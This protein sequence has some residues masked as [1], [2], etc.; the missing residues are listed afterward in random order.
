MLMPPTAAGSA[1]TEAVL[2]SIN[3]NTYGRPYGHLLGRNGQ[4]Y[5]TMA[6]RGYAPYCGGYF[7]IV[8]PT[9]PGRPWRQIASVLP[10]SITD[11]CYDGAELM[12]GFAAD[13]S[14]KMYTT[15]AGGGP[16]GITVT[17]YPEGTVYELTT[18]GRIYAFTGVSDGGYPVGDV[19]PLTSGVYGATA[20]GGMGFGTVFALTPPATGPYGNW[21]ETVLH[22]FA[23]GAD[24]SG[25]RSG[26]LAFQGAFFGTT[27]G[28]GTSNAGTVYVVKQ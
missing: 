26:L 11:A 28:G 8:P 5:G 12:A 14:G 13:A 6:G 2:S 24:G 22:A 3:D 1:W 27:E 23:G 18:F 21:T 7:Q 9:P 16:T 19:L 25:P 20:G 17:G 15:A 10:S 4:L